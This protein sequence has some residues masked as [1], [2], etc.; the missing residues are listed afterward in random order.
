MHYNTYN[1]LAKHNNVHVLPHPVIQPLPPGLSELGA[2]VPGEMLSPLI[3]PDAWTTEMS[4][5]EKPGPVSYSGCWNKCKS[6]ISDKDIWLFI[7]NTCVKVI[8]A[9]TVESN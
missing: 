2:I 7:N 6:T 8:N 1:Q 9:T 3:S 4:L 5:G